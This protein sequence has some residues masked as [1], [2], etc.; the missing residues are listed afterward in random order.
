MKDRLP[1]P[2]FTEVNEANE[3]LAWTSL[4][5]LTSVTRQG[6][7]FPVLDGVADAGISNQSLEATDRS[8]SGL[9][10]EPLIVWSP[11]LP[12]PQLTVR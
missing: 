2:V 12:V 4:P 5:S 1:D 6:F 8:A 7:H 9:P 11:R 3:E 10:P